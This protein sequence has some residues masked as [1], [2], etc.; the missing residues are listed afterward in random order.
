MAERYMF[1]RNR[2]A[3]G[4]TQIRFFEKVFDRGNMPCNNLIINYLIEA[5]TGYRFQVARKYNHNFR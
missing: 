5:V 3:P 2:Q 4:G 1:T